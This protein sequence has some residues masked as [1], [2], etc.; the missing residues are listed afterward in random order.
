MP[1]HPWQRQ[2]GEAPADFTAFVAYLRLPGRRSLRMTATQTRRSLGALRRLST[3]F[4][5]IGRVAAF[6]TRLAD[7]TQDALNR[8]V[9]ATATRSAA[10]C[11]R[12]R[13]SEFLLAQRVLR[14]SNR[15]L[16][17]AS[18][19]HRRDY[20]LLQVCRVIELATKLG[21]LAVGMPLG[22]Q[23]GRPRRENTPGYWT[24]PSLEEAC[25]R[26]YGQPS[27]AAITATSSSPLS[28][29]SAGAGADNPPDV[30]AVP[31]SPGSPESPTQPN[32]SAPCHRPPPMTTGAPPVVLASPLPRRD[33]WASWNRLQRRAA[34]PGRP[35]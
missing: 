12:L 19:P 26:I 33:A 35:S 6:E 11:E 10:D 22:N 5:W 7:A 14:E 15:W 34:N 17:L 1:P 31:N 23:P 29:A 3:R 4:N 32:Q 30:S 13:E 8:L 9:R 20:S 28:T 18:N 25:T 2:P 21:R 27:G 16:E 24:G